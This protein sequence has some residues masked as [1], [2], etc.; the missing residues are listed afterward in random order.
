M[1][2]GFQLEIEKSWG[3]FFDRP[4]EVVDENI[5][6]FMNW[7]DKIIES[8]EMLEEFKNFKPFSGFVLSAD[9][10]LSYSSVEDLRNDL[11]KALRNHLSPDIKQ[12]LLEADAELLEF[13]DTVKNEMRT[14]DDEEEL[15]GFCQDTLKSYKHWKYLANDHITVI[16]K[17]LEKDNMIRD[18]RRFVLPIIKHNIDKIPY[19]MKASTLTYGLGLYLPPKKPTAKSVT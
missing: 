4:Y 6:V 7:M 14:F 19:T 1:R 2:H 5:P 13:I 8:P 16:I 3:E 10:G 9:I 17:L 11:K 18:I 15:S 12:K